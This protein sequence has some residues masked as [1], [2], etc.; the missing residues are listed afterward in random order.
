MLVC[1]YTPYVWLT[2]QVRWLYCDGPGDELPSNLY[3]GTLRV[4][5]REVTAASTVCYV[6]L[7]FKPASTHTEPFNQA[8]SDAWTQHYYYRS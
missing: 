4:V 1:T 2:T 6:G 5:T 8:A 3:T 7:L